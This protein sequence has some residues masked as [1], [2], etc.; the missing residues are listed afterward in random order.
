L[1]FAVN[2]A[3]SVSDMLKALGHDIKLYSNL[4]RAEMHIAL[5]EFQTV[6]PDYDVALFFMLAMVLSAMV[7]TY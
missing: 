4:N 3:A 5:D 6:L 7:T 2:D 1:D